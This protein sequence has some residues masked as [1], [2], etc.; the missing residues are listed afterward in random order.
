MVVVCFSKQ[1]IVITQMWID[2]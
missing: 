2:L 1:K